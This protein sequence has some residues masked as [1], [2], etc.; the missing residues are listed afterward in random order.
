MLVSQRMMA[1]RGIVREHTAREVE[2]VLVDVQTAN[3]IVTLYDAINA[4]NQEYLESLSMER[5][6]VIAWRL[7]Q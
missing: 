5:M 6:G 2:G 1:V 4:E 7:V 3:A